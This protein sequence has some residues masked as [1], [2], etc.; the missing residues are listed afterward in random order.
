MHPDNNHDYGKHVILTLLS[1]IPFNASYSVA[2]INR[3]IYDHN[4]KFEIISDHLVNNC[5][6]EK[7]NVIHG[8][9]YHKKGNLRS[10]I[11]AS[12]K[13]VS[14]FLPFL[15][16][17]YDINDSFHQADSI[18]SRILSGLHIVNVVLL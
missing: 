16:L 6:M 4:V 8:Q 1:R 5:Q 3:L 2:K 12:N 18:S 15:A 13:S 11:I 17:Q 7:C 10:T 9:R 14:Q